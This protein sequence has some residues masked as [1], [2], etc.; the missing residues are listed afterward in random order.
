MT[1]RA[2][3]VHAQ[4]GERRFHCDDVPGWWSVA[5]RRAHEAEMRAWYAG[6]LRIPLGPTVRNRTVTDFACGPDSLLHVSRCWTEAHAVDPLT[7]TDE[8]EAR[9]RDAGIVRHIGTAEAYD[10]P[11]TDEAWAYNCLQHTYDWAMA[12]RGIARTARHTVR[13]FEW[14]EVP[15]DELHLHTLTEP[16]LRNVL[17]SE[18]FREVLFVRGESAEHPHWAQRFYASVWER[19]A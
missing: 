5:D 6:M 3:W 4:T 10:K 15:T 7:F 17:T 2:A 12:L 9:Y 8:D 16:A 11:Q 1:T 14:V 18:G 13:L 19:A